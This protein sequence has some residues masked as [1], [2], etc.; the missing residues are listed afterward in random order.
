MSE[1]EGA[2]A[3]GVRI[4]DSRTGDALHGDRR[5]QSPHNVLKLRSCLNEVGARRIG[6]GEGRGGAVGRNFVVDPH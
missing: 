2:G 4:D 5:N 3:R 1:G 6:D